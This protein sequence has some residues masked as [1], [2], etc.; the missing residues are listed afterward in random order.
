MAVVTGASAGIGEATAIRLAREPGTARIL[1][2]RL[3]RRVLTGGA[4][5]SLTTSTGGE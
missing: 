3:T 1:L 4:A 2:P 5:S